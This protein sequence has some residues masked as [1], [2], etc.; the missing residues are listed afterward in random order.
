M[1]KLSRRSKLLAEMRGEKHDPGAFIKLDPIKKVPPKP[2]KMLADYGLH[3][4]NRGVDENKQFVLHVEHYMVAQDAPGEWQLTGGIN[5]DFLFSI[6]MGDEEG[7]Q[8]K[9]TNPHTFDVRLSPKDKFTDHWGN[10]IV[11]FRLKEIL[12]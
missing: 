11:P 5:D 7:K 6:L 9:S 4:H 10:E 12:D 2:E 1:G 8:V 3:L